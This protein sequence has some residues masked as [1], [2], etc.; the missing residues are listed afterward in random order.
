[1]ESD[2][3]YH[4]FDMYEE[5]NFYANEE[6]Q[7]MEA[8]Q[9]PPPSVEPVEIERPPSRSG[10]ES[11]RRRTGNT[12]DRPNR[13]VSSSSHPPIRKLQVGDSLTMGTMG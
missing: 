10:S 2:G 1:M 5:E 8:N 3:E 7:K 6:R 13:D 4:E 11:K 12:P 9:E